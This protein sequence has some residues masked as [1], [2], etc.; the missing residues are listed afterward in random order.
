MG[1]FNL[2]ADDLRILADEI[3]NLKITELELAREL[4]WISGQLLDFLA[5][6]VNHS[7]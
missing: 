2:I 7:N 3:D 6:S 4:S 5:D 1:D